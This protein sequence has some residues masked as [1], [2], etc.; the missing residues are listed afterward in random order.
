[1]EKIC[2]EMKSSDVEMAIQILEEKSTPHDA[3]THILLN[4]LKEIKKCQ[5]T[6]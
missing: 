6:K 1:M 2:I 3:G 4:K 5:W